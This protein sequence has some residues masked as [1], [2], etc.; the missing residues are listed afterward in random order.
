MRASSGGWPAS[1][2][3]RPGSA[4]GSYSASRVTD[5]FAPRT[6]ISS[7]C[8]G[9]AKRCL[10][11]QRVGVDD[12]PLEDRHLVDERVLDAA[13][14]LVVAVVDGYAVRVVPGREDAYEGEL[15]GAG[16]KRDLLF[17]ETGLEVD[18][19]RLERA[20]GVIY[21][22]EAERQSHCSRP[23]WRASSMPWCTSTGRRR[24]GRSTAIPAGSPRAGARDVPV[25]RVSGPATR[26][27]GSAER[28][29]TNVSST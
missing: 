6:Y 18:R 24:S 17:F 4:L 3:R 20:I 23:K 29:Q 21:R 12:E 8:S 13:D 1:R 19:R 22:P 16:L 27:S 9:A 7:I 11:G 5:S 10:P 15:H 2:R 25:R 28:G 14:A 26:R